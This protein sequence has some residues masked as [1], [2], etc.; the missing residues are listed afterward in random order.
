VGLKSDGYND[1][2]YL[3]DNGTPQKHYLDIDKKYD[4]LN[5]KAGFSWQSGDYRIYGSVAMSHREPERNNFT[6]NGSY[7]APKAE[8]LMDYELGFTHTKKDWRFGLNL[9]Y[10]DY[11][12]QFVQTGAVS[13]IGESLTTN[14]SD[15]YRMGAEV[16]LGFDFTPWLSF[17]ANASASL[18]KIKD[19][20]EVIEDWTNGT[21]TIHH[22]NSTLAFSPS[23]IS[24]VFLNFHWNGLQAII[25][26]QHVSRQYLDNSECDDRSLPSYL[27][28]NASVSYTLKPKK[29]LKE[30]VF[31]L[32]FSNLFNKRYA[33]GGWVY[34]AV[35][36]GSGFTPDN[37]YYQ[38]GFIPMAGFTMMGNVTL[39]F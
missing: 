4:F 29:I 39:C 21:C 18:N 24:N 26:Q 1:K 27:V 15:S 13:D 34:S 28:Y 32:N 20:D 30:T 7:P 2:Y 12:D 22:D 8:Q 9:Y 6:D 11:K 35:D 31:S 33:N 37:R 38:I 5:P 25:Q 17:E 16:Q 14:I 23:S 3:D 19:F 10:M 36:E